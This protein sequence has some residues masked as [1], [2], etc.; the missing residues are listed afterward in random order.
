M[1]TG[2]ET[3]NVDGIF[4]YNDIDVNKGYLQIRPAHK[5]TSLTIDTNVAGKVLMPF[6]G[7]LIGVR[8]LVDTAGITGDLRVQVQ[9]NGSDTLSTLVQIDTGETDSADS[10]VT[11]VISDS[12]FSIGDVI[13][14]DIDEVQT[15]TAPKGLLVGLTFNRTLGV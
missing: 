11:V 12:A 5:L 14:I 1:A 2:F 9:K 7:T 3:D 15:G 13:T 10:V 6:T 4:S 8:I